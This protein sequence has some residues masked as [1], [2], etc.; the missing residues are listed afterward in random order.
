MADWAIVREV[1]QRQFRARL[2]NRVIMDFE[3]SRRGHPMDRDRT[4]EF[5][6]H[7]K[8][9]GCIDWTLAEPN[10]WSHL[11]MIEE[12]FDDIKGAFLTLYDLGRELMGDDNV[13]F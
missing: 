1:G 9:D 5:K 12:E 8:W 13:D 4:A 7:V 2:A 6:G 11:C 10:H 3:I